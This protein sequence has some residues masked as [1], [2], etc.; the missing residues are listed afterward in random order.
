MKSTLTELCS[1]VSL[2]HLSW[3]DSSMPWFCDQGLH[4]LEYKDMIVGNILD[5]S[6]SI[7]M[8]RWKGRYISV[9][10]RFVGFLWVTKASQDLLKP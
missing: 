10:V 1:A 5:A 7:Y 3:E 6:E 8:V 2:M 9:L 4:D